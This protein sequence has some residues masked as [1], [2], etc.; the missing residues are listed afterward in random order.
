ML[1]DC[2]WPFLHYVRFICYGMDFVLVPSMD[3]PPRWTDPRRS[4]PRV[5]L[6]THARQPLMDPSLPLT[7]V[8]LYTCSN[9]DTCSP[10][11]PYLVLLTCDGLSL[12]RLASQS[13]FL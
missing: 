7:I 8:A 2:P 10:M 4:Y 5:F 9:P 6:L 12:I 11:V 3:I 1:A 13:C